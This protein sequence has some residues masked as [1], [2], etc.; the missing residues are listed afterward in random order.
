M[1]CRGCAQI[2]GCPEDLRFGGV[3]ETVPRTTGSPAPRIRC[4]CAFAASSRGTCASYGRLG[5]KWAWV[6]IQ[7]PGQIGP[8]LALLKGKTAS[9]SRVRFQVESACFFSDP[10]GHSKWR[11]LA[12]QA[13]IRTGNGWLQIAHVFLK[14]PAVAAFEKGGPE[15]NIW[16]PDIADAGEREGE[17]ER[18][19]ISFEQRV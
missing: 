19:E 12:V 14:S 5:L 1:I 13:S 18:E 7:P 3:S 6:K 2:P 16:E 4:E 8:L 9:C 11:G 17:R 10:A 15:Q